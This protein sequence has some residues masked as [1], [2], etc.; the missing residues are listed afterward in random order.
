MVLRGNIDRQIATKRFLQKVIRI[1]HKILDLGSENSMS[2]FLKKENYNI[3]NTSSDIDFDYVGN[4]LFKYKNIDVVTAFEVLEHLFSPLT[5]LE[6]LPANKLV[7]SIPLKL[8]FANA[9]MHIPVKDEGHVAYGHYHEFEVEQLNMLLDKTG[10]KILYAEKWKSASRKP[11][12]IRPILR[13]FFNRYYIVYCE[14]VEPYTT[15]N[16]KNK[17]PV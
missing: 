1:E 16:Y 11:F 17:K 4:S 5:I 12:G 2:N 15:G 9:Y 7:L 10:W 14:K 8:W 13:Y 3:I 6:N